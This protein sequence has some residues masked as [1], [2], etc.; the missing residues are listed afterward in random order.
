VAPADAVVLDIAKLSEGSV[1][2]EAEQFFTLVP[3]SEDL[4]AEVQVDSL[5]IGYI[6][7]GDPVHLKLDAFDFQTHGVLEGKVRTIS[8]DAFR[9]E[10]QNTQGAESYY[11]A[12]VSFGKA[13]LKKM[14]PDA[15]LLPGMTLAGEVVVG[16][17]SVM[18]YLVGPVT[19]AMNESIRE[20]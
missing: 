5:D 7:V 19:K 2:K 4:E 1:V 13:R 9:R 11:L 18:S 8:Q 10:G 6:K 14:T 3:L 17:R 12:R 15:R 20:P 16:K